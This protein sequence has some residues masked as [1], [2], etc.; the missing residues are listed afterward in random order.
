MKGFLILFHKI[1]E[2]GQVY[3]NQVWLEC[4]SC[5]EGASNIV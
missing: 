3:S 1:C 4:I 2:T 5:F